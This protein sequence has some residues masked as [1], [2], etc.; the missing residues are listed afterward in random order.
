MCFDTIII[1]IQIIRFCKIINKKR[2]NWEIILLIVF[3][4]EINIYLFNNIIYNKL[5]LL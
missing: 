5:L 3:C 4:Q 1:N 2:K